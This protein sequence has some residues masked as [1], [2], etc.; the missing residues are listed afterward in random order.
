MTT[1]LNM[2][3][4]FNPFHQNEVKSEVRERMRK[5][6]DVPI[7][8]ITSGETVSV[9]EESEELDQRTFSVVGFS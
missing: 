7:H 3:T 2:P 4:F 1:F 8:I 6:S 5:A 9:S